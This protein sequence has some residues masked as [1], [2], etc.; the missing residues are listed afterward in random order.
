MILRRY[1]TRRTLISKP[2]RAWHGIY[3]HSE[4]AHQQA[5]ELKAQMPG[6]E[7]KVVLIGNRD[8]VPGYTRLDWLRQW[9][10]QRIAPF[11]RRDNYPDFEEWLRHEFKEAKTATTE[12]TE[13]PDDGTG[14]QAG[15]HQVGARLAS[16]HEA[17]A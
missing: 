8:R 7:W 5:R 13:E 6:A 10:P 12:A 9:E 16:C 2:L 1:A 4:F 17:E 3:L 14:I 11:I 15:K